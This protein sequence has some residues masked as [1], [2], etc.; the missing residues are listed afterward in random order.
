MPIVDQYIYLG[1]ELSTE[2]SWDTHISKVIGKG[3]AHIAKM[4]AVLTDSYLDTRIK[5]CTPMK[6][7][8]S[9]L[10]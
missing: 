7:I 4:D 6:L 9:K 3:Q 1:V 8:V 10:E 5:R 2:C